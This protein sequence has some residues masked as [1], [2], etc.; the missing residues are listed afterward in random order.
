MC[1]RHLRPSSLLILRPCCPSV[2]ALS[3]LLS[4]G[5]RAQQLTRRLGVTHGILALSACR[6]A[7]AHDSSAAGHPVGHPVGTQS[8]PSPS[9]SPVGLHSWLIL[10]HLWLSFR[11]QSSSRELSPSTVVLF[12]AG[13]SKVQERKGLRP[14][15]GRIALRS[16]SQR[17]ASMHV[18]HCKLRS[19]AMEIGSASTAQ[20]VRS[21]AS[22][23]A[24]CAAPPSLRHARPTCKAMPAG[25]ALR[26]HDV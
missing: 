3:R 16:W 7:R 17:C 9:A 26:Q 15:Y 2:A 10:E 8:W 20:A 13:W 5:M 11:S 25:S 12:T 14:L 18:L 24:G 1:S 6:G 19:Y 21:T 23:R 4:H 22:C